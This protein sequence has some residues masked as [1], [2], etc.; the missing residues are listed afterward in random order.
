MSARLDPLLFHSTT[1]CHSVFSCCSPAWFFQRRLVAS[2]SVATREPL[3]VLR[4]SG[5][6]PRFPIRMTLFKLRL[7]RTSTVRSGRERGLTRAQYRTCNSLRQANLRHSYRFS[8]GSGREFKPE[9][10]GVLPRAP[11]VAGPLAHRPEPGPPVERLCRHV[12][13]P[14]LEE[15]L[16]R[17]AAA[18][19]R[20]PGLEQ[21]AGDAPPP[22]GGLDR[23]VQDLA[24]PAHFA[25]DQ[26]PHDRGP[27]LRHEPEA[28]RR[29]H[30][31]AE[32]RL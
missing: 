10:Q 2:D 29:R 20:E 13:D 32:A 6:A 25:P 24:A 15:H 9:H 18:E 30:R 7:T 21:R 8:V 11:V 14:D 17:A 5:S 4:T 22:E 3:A 28:P 31:L 12:R 27:A 19:R 16:A 26:I 23:E 1:R